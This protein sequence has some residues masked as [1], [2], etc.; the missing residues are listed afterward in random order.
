MPPSLPLLTLLDPH[1]ACT[2][3][4]PVILLLVLQERG[5]YETIFA[6]GFSADWKFDKPWCFFVGYLMI[7]AICI[8]FYIARRLKPDW[9]EPP[10]E[11]EFTQSIFDTWWDCNPATEENSKGNE[12]WW[13]A[14]AGA[15]AAAGTAA[16]AGPIGH[17]DGFI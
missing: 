17:K 4:H 13:K 8:L 12:E 15:N 16:A 2:Y 9:L 5:G 10:I 6:K 11:D 14:K 3:V 1:P 7:A